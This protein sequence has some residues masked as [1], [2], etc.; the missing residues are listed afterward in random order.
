MRLLSL[1]LAATALAGG[2]SPT[3]AAPVVPTVEQLAAFPKMSGFRVSPDGKH[4]V[5]LEGRGEERVILVWD[6]ADLKAKPTVIGSTQM[7][8]QNVEFVKNDVLV[9]S[10]WQPYDA[11]F[12][13][14][15]KTFVTKAFLTDLQGKNW[16]EPLPVPRAKSALEEEVQAISVPELLDDLP[17]D[18]DHILLV[19]NVGFN[20]GDVYKV[21]VRT[22]RATRIQRADVNTAGYL[23]DLD[24]NLR[25]RIKLDTDGTGAHIA[26]QFRSASG[27][28]DE[29]F[30]TY[31]K[32][33]DVFSVIGFTGDPNIALIAS[34]VGEDKVGIFEYDIAARRKGEP[35]FKHKFFEAE[36][37]T[38]AKSKGNEAGQFGEVVSLQYDGP[39]QG[40]TL[41]I[42]DKHKALDAGIRKA[43]GIASQ[44]LRVV[45]PATGDSAMINYDADRRINISSSSKDLKT[46]TF[47]VSAPNTP[48]SIYLYKDGAIS[49]LAK[50]YPD[51]DPKA[52]GS[53]QLVYYKARDGLDIPAFLTKPSPELCGPGPWRSVVHPH[54][55]PW[56]RDNLGFDGSMWVPLMVSRCMSVLQPQFRGSQGWGRKLWMAG[57][58]EWG[59]KMQDDKDDGAKW[60]IEQKL[61]ISG[62]IAMFGFSYGGYSAM[63]AG[64]RP[65]GLYKCAIAGAGVS[66]IKKIWE[67]FYTNPYFRQGQAPTVKGLSPL[68]FADKIKIPMMIYQGERDRT[69]P[70]EQ[71]VWF[72]EKAKKSGQ[73]VEFHMLKDYGHGPAW[74]RAIMAQQLRYIDDYF[75]KG[76]GGGGL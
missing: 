16:R 29:H 64:V 45:D 60:M 41:W 36:N 65:N 63:A 35:L 72:A 5:A 37:V 73:P 19:N 23:A 38:V 30:R 53:T 12:D 61:A 26:T 22:N 66:D 28:W 52:M 8:I 39:N 48:P 18:P 2:F 51:I 17:N 56:G 47:A 74:T 68:E 75:S 25:A 1:A 42:S 71:S 21:N 50:T 44:P 11:R 9:V 15:T 58:A 10:L 46:V 24:G 67:Q 31:V 70:P 33:R 14:V 62:R 55:G 40:D 69:V 7:K 4:M 32:N 13:G 6:T 27:G 43:L 54:G 34:N 59:Q 76:C 3:I 49:L 57:D 20:S